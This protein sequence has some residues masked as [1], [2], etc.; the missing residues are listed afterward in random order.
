MLLSIG[1]SRARYNPP[2]AS[3]SRGE[4]QLPGEGITPNQLGQTLQCAQV[5][6]QPDINL[7][8]TKAPR[9]PTNNRQK[10]ER[11]KKKLLESSRAN[12]CFRTS[13]VLERP[14]EPQLCT[15]ITFLHGLC[16]FNR[17]DANM[18][19]VYLFDRKPS[20]RRCQAD[21]RCAHKVD[22]ASYTGRVYRRY[23]RLR[24][25]SPAHVATG[26]VAGHGSRDRH[27]HQTYSRKRLGSIQA[28]Q[29]VKSYPPLQEMVSGKNTP[30]K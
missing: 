25:A 9:H 30:S 22:A 26:F 3:P 21:V 5:R 23:D 18:Y 13:Q 14:S 16:S 11:K 28:L 19:T 4:D 12:L 2:L 15:R 6:A 24:T 8:H 20:I 10:N 29:E 7:V 17:V 1:I 27:Q